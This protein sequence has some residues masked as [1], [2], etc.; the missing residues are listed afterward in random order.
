MKRLLILFLSI[1]ILLLGFSCFLKL[2]L[3]TA[4][5]YGFNF[6]SVYSSFLIILISIITLAIIAVTKKPNLKTWKE[7][8]KAV[9]LLCIAIFL[10]ILLGIIDN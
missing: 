3:G 8:R 9:Y 6:F 10:A 5:S 4:E 1:A 7:I 2:I